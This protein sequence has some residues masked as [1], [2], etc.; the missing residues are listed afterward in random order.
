RKATG[1]DFADYK[2]ATIKRRI[3]RR[4]LILKTSK[5]QDYMNNLKTNPGEVS[6]LFQDILINVTG[7]FREPQTFD[8]LKQEVFPSIMK[9]RSADDPIRIWIPGCSTGEE[10]YSLAIC[11][12]EYLDHSSIHPPIQIFATD[13]NETVLEKA[14][15]GVYAASASISAERLRRFFVGM[16][17]SFQVN[18]TIRRMC[19]FVKM[20]VTEYTQY[21][22]LVTI[23]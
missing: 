21:V 18:K 22:T 14:R 23:I 16:Y 4:M 7:F 6:S 17:G 8:A 11:L 15:D 5:M 3:L 20:A 10:V 13:V 9:K 19:V 12:V 1:V 2:H